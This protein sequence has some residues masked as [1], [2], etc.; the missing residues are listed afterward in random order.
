MSPCSLALAGHNCVQDFQI[1]GAF[2]ADWFDIAAKAATPVAVPTLR[3]ML[4]TLFA[5][6]FK[7][8]FHRD[9]KE[10]SSL[11]LVVSKGGPKLRGSQEDAPGVLRR[12]KAAMMAQHATMSEFVGTPA[13]PLRTPVIDKTG[14]T[15]RYDFTVDLSSYFAD[16]KPGQQPDMTGITMSALR[17]QLGLNLESKKGTVEILVIDH[18]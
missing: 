17:E 12:D 18:C 16:A 7:L 11:V 1:S 3:R 5:E 13:G 9:A 15:A 14:L 4:G 6:R 2:A 10:P 8:A